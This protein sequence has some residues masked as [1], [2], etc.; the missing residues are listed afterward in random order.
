MMTG[1]LGGISWR[2]EDLMYTIGDFS[3]ITGLTVKTFG[4]ITSKGS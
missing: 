1:G 2:H 4:F 3:K